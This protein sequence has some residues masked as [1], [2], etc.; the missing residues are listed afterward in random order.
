LPPLALLLY[1]YGNRFLAVAKG[2]LDASLQR[3]APSIEEAASS[4]GQRWP[5]VLY[6]IHLPLLRSPLLLGGLLVFVD[7]IKELPLTFALR[8]FKFDTLAVRVYQYAGDERLG[9]AIVPA[10]I[11]VVLG[12]S[13]AFTLV[14]QLRKE[15]TAVNNLASS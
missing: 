2:G 10:L 13:A 11:I 4:L 14:P 15:T 7:T 6:R 5:G 12:L 8:P 1:G 3:L 9:A